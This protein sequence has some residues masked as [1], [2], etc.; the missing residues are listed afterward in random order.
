V[1]VRQLGEG[2]PSV[3]VVGTIHGD[4]PCGRRG[5]ERLLAD[6][7][8]VKRPVKLVVA[9]ETA[10]EQGV[11][12]VDDDLNRAYP[13]DPDADSHER[14]LAAAL[15]REL[16]GCTTLSL[17]STQS[18]AEPFAITATVDEIAQFVVPRL[19]VTQLVESGGFSRG[20]FIEQPHTLEVECGLQR[21]DSAAANAYW[22]I[23]AFLAATNAL[24]EPTTDDRIHSRGTETIEVFRLADRIGKPPAD[25]YEVL[26]HNF[27]RV[28]PQETF[29]VADG[30]EFT[31]DE[32][33]YP[34]LMSAHG[35]T[36]VFGYA[37]ERI[38]SLS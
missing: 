16:D 9:N 35:Y 37:A 2:T 23:R 7:P 38:G 25:S 36:D 19:P 8:E 26:A 24:P 28:A 31:A 14:R 34:V 6:D 30:T 22:L 12:Y 18:Y 21:S 33:F 13:G 11:R 5:I 10:A 15:R 1:Q 29:A 32:E 17:H 27:E 3:A 20:R 4:E